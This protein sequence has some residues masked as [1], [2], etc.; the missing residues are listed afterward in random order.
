M[1]LRLDERIQRKTVDTNVLDKLPTIDVNET[2]FKDQCTICMES[3]NLGQQI[4]SLPCAHMFHLHCIE[5]YLK[6]FSTKC[7][8]D[9]LSII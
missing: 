3:Y 1:L 5:A 9:N 4:K 6:E 7:P 2:H 8:L